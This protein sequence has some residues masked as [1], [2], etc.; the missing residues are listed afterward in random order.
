MGRSGGHRAEVRD[1][2][3]L[4]A[5]AGARVQGG[6]I[7]SATREPPRYWPR[8]WDSLAGDDVRAIAADLLEACEAAL[9]RFDIEEEIPAPRS[10]LRHAIARAR[11]EP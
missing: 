5:E 4:R 8:Q 11:A 1:L 7:V 2:A 10:L 6:S 3:Q 9:T